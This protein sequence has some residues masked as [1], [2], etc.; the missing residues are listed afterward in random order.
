LENEQGFFFHINYPTIPG[1]ELDLSVE[2][3]KM[4]VK[5]AGLGRLENL[6]YHPK[7]PT[8]KIHFSENL[9]YYT[10]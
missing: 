8:S 7:T 10:S 5:K 2:G 9:G 1:S 6:G 4:P 3:S